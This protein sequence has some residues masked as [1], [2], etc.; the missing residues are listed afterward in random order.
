M[1]SLGHV[2]ER[3]NR[4]ERNL[5]IRDILGDADAIR[6]CLHESFR[7]RVADALGIAPIPAN[8]WWGTDYHISWLAGALSVFL[9]RE[10][11]IYC[12]KRHLEGSH[13]RQLVEGNQEDVDL[14]IATDQHLILI[15]V[16]A[17]SGPPVS[18]QLPPG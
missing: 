11:E 1:Q 5:L 16:K 3:F 14:I 15:E 2:L 17:Y 9:K 12:N 10:P 13:G 7:K 8:A 18:D 4:K 6:L